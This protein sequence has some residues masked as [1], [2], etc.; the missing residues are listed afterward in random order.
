VNLDARRSVTLFTSK[1]N[2]LLALTEA[3]R[4]ATAALARGEAP[5]LVVDADFF[6]KLGA[7]VAV[8][9]APTIVVGEAIGV[10]QAMAAQGKQP[11]VLY[12]V[13]H[14]QDG[15]ALIE[16]LTDQGFKYR[17]VGGYDVGGY[18]HDD[19]VARET[20]EKAL[21]E[22][23]FDGYEKFCDP[24]SHQD[25]VNLAQALYRTR[26][27]SGDVVEVGCFRGSS[28]SVMLD[29]AANKN[30][31]PR[32]FWFFDVFQGFDYQEA[33]ASSDATWANSHA[34][35]GDAIVRQRLEGK[36][37]ANRVTVRKLNIITDEIPHDLGPIAVANIDVDLYEAVLA[38]LTRI[39]PLMQVG[40][41]MI[42][43]D[44]GHTP[45]LVGAALALEQ[46]LDSDLGGGFTPVHMTSGQTFLVRHS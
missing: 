42:C 7:G 8:S 2:H 28:G 16:W 39:A 10:L 18:V 9:S 43:E 29:Y 38:G 46:F 3:D 23:T 13:E 45:A 33:L 35:E 30:L 27:L 19:R 11:F 6:T 25:F 17:G 20:I 14:A 1:I 22:Q 41:I 12:A 15:L 34:T 26:R 24:G 37:G 32:H 31:P 21:L 44:A 4:D 5:C 36:A 40:G